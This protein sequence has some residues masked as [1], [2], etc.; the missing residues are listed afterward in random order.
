VIG[1]LRIWIR[2][3]DQG[4]I[5]P[6]APGSLDA[7]TTHAAQ[8]EWLA[9][10]SSAGR[11][12]ITV[13]PASAEWPGAGALLGPDGQQ[14]LRRFDPLESE[15][16]PQFVWRAQMFELGWPGAWERNRTTGTGI[17]SPGARVANAAELGPKGAAEEADCSAGAA[18]RHHFGA[19]GG[20]GSSGERDNRRPPV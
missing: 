16:P 14:R 6:L 1:F 15:G 4:G 5:I 17:I 18:A 10:D 9:T 2:L 20:D 11:R 3:A 8:Q 13:A 12:P 7:L 19:A